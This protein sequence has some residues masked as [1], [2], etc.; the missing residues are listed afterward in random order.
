VLQAELRSLALPTLILVGTY[1]FIFGPRWAHL[2]HEAIHSYQ[3][4]TFTDSGHMAHLEQADEFATTITLSPVAGA[5]SGRPAVG[6]RP[7]WGRAGPRAPPAV[8]TVF[9]GCGGSD[10]AWAERH[11]EDGRHTVRG[12]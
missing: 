7:G 3:R 5:R 11:G 6:R 1:D 2:L 4:V 8:R 10:G 12:R 9:S